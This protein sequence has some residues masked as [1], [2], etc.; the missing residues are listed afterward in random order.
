[1]EVTKKL[2]FGL[3]LGFLKDRLLLNTTYARNR[4]SNQLLD[5]ALPSITGKDGIYQNFHTTLQNTSWG[6]FLNHSKSKTKNFS[7]EQL[8][9]SNYSPK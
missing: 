3:D 8:C 9:E 1:M 6:V 7:L 2:Q 4:S 5:Y